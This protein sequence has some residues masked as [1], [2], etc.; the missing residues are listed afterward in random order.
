MLSSI[1][2]NGRLHIGDG[3]VQTVHILLSQGL[4]R[5]AESLLVQ[6]V[7]TV[8]GRSGLSRDGLADGTK[9]KLHVLLHELKDSLSDASLGAGIHAHRHGWSTTGKRFA[10]QS[11]I[12]DTVD[13]TRCFAAYADLFNLCHTL[14]GFKNVNN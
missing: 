13:G 3:N 10:V 9:V 4:Q 11:V 8:A 6:A 7:V 2:A 5:R 12:G 1:G 14:N